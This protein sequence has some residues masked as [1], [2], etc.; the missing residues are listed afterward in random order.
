[1]RRRG[2]EF[3]DGDIAAYDVD[4]RPSFNVLQNHRSA[5]CELYFY[6]FTLLTPRGK[7]LTRASLEAALVFAREGDVAIALAILT[8]RKHRRPIS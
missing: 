1:M 5:G 2:G 4:V 6:A 8:R 3:I 7:G